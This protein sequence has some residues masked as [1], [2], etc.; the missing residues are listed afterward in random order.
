MPHPT[1]LLKR[2]VIPLEVWPWTPKIR[3]VLQE[4]GIHRTDQAKNTLQIA[5]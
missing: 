1:R 2:C 5:T 3:S 4:S